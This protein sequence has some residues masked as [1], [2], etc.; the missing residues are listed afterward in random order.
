MGGHLRPR[1]VPEDLAGPGQ[2]DAALAALEQRL[3]QLVL[4]PLDRPGQRRRAHVQSLGGAREVQAVRQLKEN[5]EL[6]LGRGRHVAIF[7]IQTTQN[8]STRNGGGRLC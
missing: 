4:E 3:P 1:V 7:A 8:R 5:T 2:G 6:L